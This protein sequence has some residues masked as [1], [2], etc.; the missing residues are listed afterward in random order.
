MVSPR[1]LV[2]DIVLDIIPDTV[3][4]FPVTSVLPLI[5]ILAIPTV[6]VAYVKS[7]RQRSSQRG[8]R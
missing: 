6:T 7:A 4:E 1:T 2:S 5:L 3:P 8:K